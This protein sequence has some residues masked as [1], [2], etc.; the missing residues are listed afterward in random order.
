MNI[1]RN[2]IVSSMVCLVV[3]IALVGESSAATVS[4]ASCSYPDVSSAIS[5]SV[6][7][8]TVT[9]PPGSCTW[10][11]TL[12]IRN[13]ITLLGAGIGNTVITYGA[14]TVS[15][16]IYEPSDASINGFFRITGFTF[17]GAGINTGGVPLIELRGGNQVTTIQTKLRIDHNRFQNS[18]TQYIWFSGIRGVIDNNV[19]G[20]TYYPIRTPMSRINITDLTLGKLYGGA[21]EWDY[22]QGVRFGAPD[23]NMYFEDNVFEGITSGIVTDCQDAGRYVFRYNTIRVTTDPWPL[24]DMHGNNG[25]SRQYSCVGGELYG[26]NVTVTGTGGYFLDQRG[27]RVFVFNNNVNIPLSFHIREEEDDSTL[28]V[29]YVGPNPPP[30]YPQHVNGS[31]YW[32]NARNLAVTPYG[33]D[34]SCKSPVCFYSG[35]IPLAGRDFFTDT[36]SPGITAGTLASR[37]AT[38]STGQG[39]WATDQSTTN[40]TGMVGA[41]PTTPISGMLYRCVAAN[42]WDSG[43]SPLAYP[44]PLRSLSGNSAAPGPPQ[45]LTV[46]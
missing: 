28:P 14:A 8:D 37:P 16:L 2:L 1:G 19:F 23:N 18:G 31:Y 27:G 41:N 38:C 15:M 25:S 35:D 4:A 33:V 40:L 42:T 7:G 5:A 29:T 3:A 46:F 39:Y 9:V 11:S 13:G 43:S 34:T 6:A 26:N 17:D 30:Q 44:H 36:T 12:T 20:T 22:W 45:N 32:G 21:A 10:S 24:F